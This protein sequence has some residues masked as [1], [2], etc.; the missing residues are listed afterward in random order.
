MTREAAQGKQKMLSTQIDTQLDALLAA[1]A[2]SSPSPAQPFLDRIAA[3]LQPTLKPVRQ[4]ANPWLLTAGLVL[5]AAL[6]ALAGAW[7]AGFNGFEKMTTPDGILIFAILAACLVLAARKLVSERIPGSRSRI[8]AAA[9]TAIAALALL[10]VFALIFRD[11]HTTH[12]VPA[13]IVC[14]FTGL[15]HAAP[16]ALLAWLI[17]RRGFSV[18]ARSSGLIAGTL[19]GLAGIAL[20]ELHCSNFQALHILLWHTSVLPV[21]A[22]AGAL[23]ARHLHPPKI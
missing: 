14:L 11:Y 15:L 13:G 6:V 23:A 19:A 12:F 5:A 10:A 16:A 21:T 18:N 20:L 17:V 1:A 2:A 22:A 3:T 4:L 8:S 9:L 7:R